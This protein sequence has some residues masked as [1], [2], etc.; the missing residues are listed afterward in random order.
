MNISSLFKYSLNILIDEKPE[1]KEGKK[2]VIASLRHYILFNS[3][4]FL[5]KI[6]LLTVLKLHSKKHLQT[7]EI[8]QEKKQTNVA[9]ISK[10]LVKRDVQTRLP[11]QHK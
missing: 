10:H 7:Y 2:N 6:T 9:Q 1:Q 11:G 5:T 3:T 4:Y 8:A